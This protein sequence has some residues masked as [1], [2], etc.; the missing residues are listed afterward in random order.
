MK[1]TLDRVWRKNQTRQ[2]DATMPAPQHKVYN[3]GAGTTLPIT[4]IPRVPPRGG[5]P[6]TLTLATRIRE[7]NALFGEMWLI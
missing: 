4:G 5:A 3:P 6:Y 2:A 7:D 1:D